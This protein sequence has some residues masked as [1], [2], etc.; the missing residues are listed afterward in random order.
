MLRNFSSFDALEC[1]VDGA[2][3]MMICMTGDTRHGSSLVGRIIYDIEIHSYD[4]GDMRLVIMKLALLNVQGC[5][6]H[7]LN[8]YLFHQGIASI[9][10]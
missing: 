2:I 4:M 6:K 1:G 10:Q 3:R 7:C 8:T 9:P 5:I